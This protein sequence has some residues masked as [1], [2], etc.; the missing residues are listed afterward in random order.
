MNFNLKK[1]KPKINME[2]VKQEESKKLEGLEGLVNAFSEAAHSLAEVKVFETGTEK[3]VKVI[4]GTKVLKE[5]IDHFMD[6]DTKDLVNKVSTAETTSDKINFFKEYSKKVCKKD[7]QEDKDREDKGKEENNISVTGVVFSNTNLKSKHID[8]LVQR[9][10]GI[11]SEVSCLSS[12]EKKEYYAELYQIP[13]NQDLNSKLDLIVEKLED[14][15]SE[16]A[17]M[18]KHLYS[19]C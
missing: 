12:S 1:N 9:E 5:I 6:E 4:D 7:E 2:E 17:I 3:P 11:N 15:S 18:R 8:Q 19:K 14:L 10:R 13:T 16:V